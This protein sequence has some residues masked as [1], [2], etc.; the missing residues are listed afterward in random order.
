MIIIS[1][2]FCCFFLRIKVIILWFKLLKCLY[3]PV[4]LSS[5][6]VNWLFLGPE[7]T[8]H[9]FAISWQ[10]MGHISIKQGNDRRIDKELIVSCSRTSL[11]R[12]LISYLPGQLWEEVLV[13]SEGPQA[14]Q[15]ADGGRQRL[16]LIATTVQ[17]LQQ[18]QTGWNGRRA[19]R[20]K[21]RESDR[22]REEIILQAA[23]YL[24]RP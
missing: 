5:M 3:F 23:E 19:E 9:F 16:Q 6:A 24:P 8:K 15:V 7:Q 14:V 10:W 12:V 20:R 17:L 11:Y 18:R 1:F 21:C 22:D 13:G 4:S 2:F